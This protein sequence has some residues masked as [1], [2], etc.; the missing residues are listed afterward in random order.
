[1]LPAALRGARCALRPWRL[2]DRPAL[3]RHANDAG[4]AANL[5]LLPHPYG[6]AAA[7]AWLAHA[8][9]DPV[10]EGLWAVEVGGEAVGCI[11]LVRGEDVEAHSFEVGYW[12]GR[13]AWGRGIATD[14]LRAVTAAAWREPGASRVYAGVFGW[15]HASMRVLE[16]AGYRRE[17]VLVRAGLKDGVEFDRVVYAA[18]RDTGRPYRAFAPP[19]A[20]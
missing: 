14:A 5:R 20:P 10:P 15:N 1:V 12:L 8:A 7:D 9:V 18:T 17:A 16:K 4:V 6:D 2:A 3:L 19:A 13:A 11:E